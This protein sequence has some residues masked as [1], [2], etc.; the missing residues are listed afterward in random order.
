MFKI[1]LKSY[2]KQVNMFLSVEN[3]LKNQLCFC[4]LLQKQIFALLCYEHI[5]GVFFYFVSFKLQE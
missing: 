3:W 4:N 5:L 1:I 2:A